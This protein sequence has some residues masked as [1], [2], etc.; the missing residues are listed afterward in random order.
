[1]RILTNLPDLEAKTNIADRALDPLP[2]KLKQGIIKTTRAGSG[3]RV[4]DHDEI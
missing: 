1:M 2:T 3:E 4:I